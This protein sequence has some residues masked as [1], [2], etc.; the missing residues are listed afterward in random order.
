MEKNTQR[1][2]Y[3]RS[4]SLLKTHRR[5]IWE[6][7]DQIV[8][9]AA[10]REAPA[11]QLLCGRSHSNAQKLDALLVKQCLDLCTPTN[12]HDLESS[13]LDERSVKEK[14]YL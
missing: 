11:V 8:V 14:T 2:I 9:D 4:Q 1:V 10:N 6:H 12:H 7:S 3:L 5:M 13:I